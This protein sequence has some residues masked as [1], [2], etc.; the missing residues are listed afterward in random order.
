[1]QKENKSYKLEL[2]LI[3][4]FKTTLL[5][6]LSLTICFAVSAKDDTSF[7]KKKRWGNKTQ[8]AEL[9]NFYNSLSVKGSDYYFPGAFRK[10][11]T[12]LLWK[13]DQVGIYY[14]RKI[15]KKFS[16]KFGYCQWN[17]WPTYYNYPDGKGFVLLA[18]H[19]NLK[20]GNVIFCAKY[21]MI[22]AFVAYTFNTFPKQQITVGMGISHAWGINAKI[23]SITIYPGYYDALIFMHN[24]SASY[25][26][27]V[28][29]SSYDFLC[30]HNRIKIGIDLMYRNYFNFYLH[31]LDY[32]FHLGI[33][34]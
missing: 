23:D 19:D 6:I 22:D 20:A 10:L 13:D 15:F 27:F 16:A 1:L 21:K 18:Q 12:V 4:M 5:F 9:K 2:K 3:S 30:L 33:N 8:S 29:E 26:G 14:E 28:P 7:I 11:G 24:E 25:N 34:F 31:S 17:T 32:G